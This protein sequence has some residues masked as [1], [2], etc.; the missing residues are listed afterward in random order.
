MHPHRAG[1]PVRVRKGLTMDAEDETR[2][3]LIALW[4]I[5]LAVAITVGILMAHDMGAPAPEESPAPAA[6]GPDIRT[7]VLT[8]RMICEKTGEHGC[9]EWR[10][11]RTVEH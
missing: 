2:A 8:G 6:P 9:A 5:A 4:P 1:K 11:Y 10:I 7:E 3:W